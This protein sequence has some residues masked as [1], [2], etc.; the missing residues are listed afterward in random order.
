MTPVRQGLPFRVALLL[1]IFVLAGGCK[2]QSAT[3][4]VR[5][6]QSSKTMSPSKPEERQQAN[7]ADH[8]VTTPGGRPVI[9]TIAGSFL[10]AP[11]VAGPFR[12]GMTVNDALAIAGSG[13][14]KLVD[15][16][17]EG[18]FT[19]ALE[20]RL[21][22]EQKEP[23]LLASIWWTCSRFSIY[24]ISIRDSRYRTSEGLGVGSTLGELR[25]YFKLDGP[26]EEAEDG[27]LS[28]ITPGVTFALDHSEEPTDN[29]KVKAVWVYPDEEEIQKHCDK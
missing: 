22:P 11:G 7:S 18:D 17:S 4:T 26:F 29:T 23:T 12:N 15:L 16:M 27:S 20:I 3:E 24:G 1:T 6:E 8:P 21:D 2:S 13:R 14:S 10:V 19:P 9:P 28:A 25:R 5:S